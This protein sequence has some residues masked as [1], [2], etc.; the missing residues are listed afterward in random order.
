MTDEPLDSANVSL[1]IG[2]AA[3]ALLLIAFAS[4]ARGTTHP[5]KDAVRG[6]QGPPLPSHDKPSECVGDECGVPSPGR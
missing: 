1:A 3:V 2:I 5:A 4:M 6:S